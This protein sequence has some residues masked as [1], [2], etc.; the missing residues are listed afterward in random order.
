MKNFILLVFVMLV[1][2]NI[3]AQT[4]YY[5][6][7]QAG[8][9]SN[10]ILYNNDGR[11]PNSKVS[12]VNQAW[13]THEDYNNK[14]DTCAVST[15]WYSPAGAA[16]DWMVIPKQT[17]ATGDFLIWRG[18][19]PDQ[20]YA[21][22]YEVKISTTDSAMNSFT[23]NLHT[24]AAEGDPWVWHAIDLSSYNGQ[25][26]WIAFRNN[27]NDKFLLFIDDITIK[28]LDSFDISGIKSTMKNPVEIN[29]APFDVKGIIRN[30]GSQ[31]ITSFDMNYSVNGGS[32]VT[33]NITGVNITTLS[34]YNFT[35]PTKWTPSAAGNYTVKMWASNIN[36][37]ADQNMSND[38]IT[39]NVS[40]ASQSTQRLPL[41]EEFTSSTCAP[42]ASGNSY[43]TPILDA[44]QGKWVMV[45]YQ[46][47]W[48]GNGD[49]YYTA[50]GGIRRKYYEV[51]AVPDMFIDGTTNIS[52]GKI[53]PSDITSA[54]GVH[55]FVNVTSTM[56]INYDHSVDIQ[57]TATPLVD[58]PAGTKMFVAIVEKETFNNVKSNGETKFLYVMKKMLPDASGTSVTLSNGNA[59]TK[60]FNYKFNGNYRLPA[61]AKSPINHSTEH[62]VENFNNLLAVVWFQNVATKE[63]YQA[64]KSTVTIGMKENNTDVIYRIYPN[65]ATDNLSIDYTLNNSSNVTY[66]IIN[67]MGQV[68]TEKELG[69]LAAGN[70]KENIDVS[71]LAAGIYMITLNID[72][73]II[74]KKVSIK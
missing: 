10:I 44:N 36:G 4:K 2:T 6:D 8:M 20:S 45:K 25:N 30:E 15:S 9:P 38:T 61:D 3:K 39:F 37:H 19:A 62:S 56:T 14:A 53:K 17:I 67:N 41:Y 28:S 35:H 54:Y 1:I 13:V 23:T 63:V 40:I 42:C 24:V 52:P 59:Y 49:P 34:T 66:T 21:D 50:E 69:T 51:N 65:P 48:P 46:M 22:G 57:I 70:H 55:A 68:V 73:Q 74:T 12:W 11:T 7:F 58:F 60:N 29:N 71:N 72:G 16:D 43:M 31:N 27:S 64:A 32:T 26:I 5:E 18:W 33:A 47:N